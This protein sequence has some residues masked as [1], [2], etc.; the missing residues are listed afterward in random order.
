MVT[1]EALVWHHASKGLEAALR[2]TEIMTGDLR[3]D[4]ELVARFAAD[5]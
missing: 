1:A 3:G 2:A 5:R 4:T